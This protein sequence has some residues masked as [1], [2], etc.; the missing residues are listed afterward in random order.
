MTFDAYN[1][2][3]LREVVH[4]LDL[5]PDVLIILPTYKLP[6][7]DRFACILGIVRLVSAHIGGAKLTL[8]QL[9]ANLIEISYIGGFM[10]EHKTWFLR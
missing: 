8:A 9:L 7:G 4:Y 1:I 5:P 6:L 3:M 10:R 2:G